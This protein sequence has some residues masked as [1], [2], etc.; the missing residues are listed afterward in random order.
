MLFV[1]FWSWWYGAGW[2]GTVRQSKRQLAG[3]AKDFSILILLRTL[4][5]PWKQIDAYGRVNQNLG[6]R[7]RHSIDKFV[8][9]FIGFLV[10][11]FTLLAAGVSFMAVLVMRAIW[12]MIWPFL[13]LFVPAMLLY[14]LGIF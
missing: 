10:R 4:F 13:P 12:I 11:F 6:D 8:S 1:A 5:A 2:A 7:F 9:R 3:V 14:S